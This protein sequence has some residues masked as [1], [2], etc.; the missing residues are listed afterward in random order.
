VP[1]P[2]PQGAQGLAGRLTRAGFPVAGPGWVLQV[3][4]SAE[5]RWGIA[6]VVALPASGLDPAALPRPVVGIALVAAL[7]G[8]C[9]TRLTSASLSSGLM[10]LR[11][12]VELGESLARITGVL[13]VAAFAAGAPLLVAVAVLLVIAAGVPVTTAI[14]IVLLAPVATLVADAIVAQPGAD[15]LTE[16]RLLVMAFLQSLLVMG[17]WLLFNLHPVAGW[18]LP[19]I[20]TGVVAWL[21]PRRLT[22]WSPRTRP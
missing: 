3:W 1:V 18:P 10:R 19:L 14:G 22:L 9:V 16:T 11:H 21:A 4:G 15:G 2:A 5:L 6:A 20:L 8:F 13:V 17:G 12:H 7:M